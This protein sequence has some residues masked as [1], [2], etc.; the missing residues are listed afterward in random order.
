MTAGAP[1]ELAYTT[2]PCAASGATPRPLFVMVHGMTSAGITFSN[3]AQRVADGAGVDVITVDLR[4]HG[5]SPD[6]PSL[7]E[8]TLTS[9]AGDLRALIV[10]LERGTKVHLLGHSWGSRVVMQFASLLPDAV[11]SVLVEDEYL[12][13][14]GPRATEKEGETAMLLTEYEA[15]K[16]AGTLPK[17]AAGEWSL[18]SVLRE[19]EAMQQQYRPYF[20][21]YAEAEAF[22][23]ATTGPGVCDFSRKILEKDVEVWKSPTDAAPSSEKRFIV[24][25]KPHVA[26]VWDYHCRVSTA[27][28]QVWADCA[29]FPFPVHVMKAGDNTSSDISTAMWDRITGE[30]GAMVAAMGKRDVSIIDGAGHPVHRTHPDEFVADTVKFLTKA[31]E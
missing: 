19:A 2:Y 11:A 20:P 22:Y 25:Y 10:M 31:L 30:C 4:G 24:L 28:S 1:V 17:D 27:A 21:S 12:V 29:A 7:T 16:A 6:G 23:N 13:A 3:V 9:M 15:A 5:G 8:C 14:V 26:H 18:D